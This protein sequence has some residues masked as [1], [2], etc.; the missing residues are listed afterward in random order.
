MDERQ[1]DRLSALL[2]AAT[3]RRA[4]LTSILTALTGLGA[5]VT[6]PDG[7]TLAGN[8]A[9]AGGQLRLPVTIPM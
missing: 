2:G 4:G 8:A 3:S 1:F 7:S 6:L 9:A 5:S